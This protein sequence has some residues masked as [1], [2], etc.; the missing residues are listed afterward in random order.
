MIDDLKTKLD[1]IQQDKH[2]LSVQIVGFPENKNET[3]DI[4]H[5]TKVF[6]EKAGVKI[7]QSDIVE[8]KRLG[9]QND[10]KTRNIILKF[11]DK[12]TRQKIYNVRKKL[13][14]NG[15]PIKSVYMNDSLTHHRQEL[16]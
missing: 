12:E 15:N 2:E 13:I 5:L 4:K 11:K 16:L 9:K 1:E 14:I 6:K 3:D 10:K 8:M 7:K